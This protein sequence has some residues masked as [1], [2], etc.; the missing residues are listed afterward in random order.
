[1]DDK[2]IEKIA[3]AIGALIKMAFEVVVIAAS[4]KILFY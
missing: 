3:S 4:I 2:T 1:M